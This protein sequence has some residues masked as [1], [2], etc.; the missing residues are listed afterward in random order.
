MRRRADRN[1]HHLK[2]GRPHEGIHTCSCRKEPPCRCKKLH[3]THITRQ[4]HQIPFLMFKLGTTS[5]NGKDID[6]WWDR[7]I[8]YAQVYVRSEIL[9]NSN[10]NYIDKPESMTYSHRGTW[11]TWCWYATLVHH[12]RFVGP[13]THFIWGWERPTTS[14]LTLSICKKACRDWREGI[15]EVSPYLTTHWGLLY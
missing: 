11:R 14:Q 7:L 8:I 12:F 10:A 6:S 15:F 5:G 3:H 4:D 9:P 1:D 2:W 13:T